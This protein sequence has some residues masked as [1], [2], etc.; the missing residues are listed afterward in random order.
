MTTCKANCVDLL[1][2]PNN[3]SSCNFFVSALLEPPLAYM[4]F[5]YMD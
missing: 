3:C 5:E 2:D 1:T 4:S